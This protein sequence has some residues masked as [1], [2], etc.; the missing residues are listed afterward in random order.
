S[1]RVVANGIGDPL[2]RRQQISSYAGSLSR[3]PGVARVDSVAGT[4]VHGTAVRGPSL[5]SARFAAANAA[6]FQVIPTV[7][8][9]SKA[10]E[11]IVRTIRDTRAPFPVLVGGAS[12]QLVDTKAALFSK[13]PL[14]IGIIGIATFVLLFMMFGSLLVP[15]KALV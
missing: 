2:A 9:Y 1:I 12:A 4:F 5:L 8:P 13:L 14:A 11:Q 6:W 3:V 15:V 7:D 10:G